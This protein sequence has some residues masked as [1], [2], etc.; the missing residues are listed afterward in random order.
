MATSTE[1]GTSMTSRTRSAPDAPLRLPPSRR[2]GRGHHRGRR[3]ARGLHRHF[4]YLRIRRSAPLSFGVSTGSA[5]WRAHADRAAS[6]STCSASTRRTWP[7][8]SPAAAPTASR[9]PPPGDAARTACRCSRTSRL[10]GLPRLA[11]IPAGDHRIVVAQAVAGD[12]GGPGR[13]L[14]LHQGRFNAL[15]TEPRRGP[16]P[17]WVVN[18]TAHRPCLTERARLY[19]RVI[20]FPGRR[21]VPVGSRRCEAPMLPSRAVRHAMQ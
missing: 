2:R 16:S 14:L 17:G 20:P 3:P 1:L 12:P 6:A 8:P 18:V 15:P 7:R 9:R 4:A 11:R 19:Y 10:A 21:G 5:S 13:P